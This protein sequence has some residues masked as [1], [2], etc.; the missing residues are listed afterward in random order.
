MPSPSPLLPAAWLARAHPASS[1]PNTPLG[2]AAITR[3]N[4]FLDLTTSQWETFLS[5]CQSASPHQHEVLGGCPI[6]ITCP[7]AFSV[8]WKQLGKL[9]EEKEFHWRLKHKDLTFGLGSLW[10]VIAGWPSI[11]DKCCYTLPL[12]LCSSLGINC[13]HPGQKIG[14]EVTW[15]LAQ[16][17]W[18]LL[19][20]GLDLCF[21]KYIRT[22]LQGPRKRWAEAFPSTFSLL[23]I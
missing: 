22:S 4:S 9:R 20:M 11:V 19:Y 8:G 15:S 7:A 3:K 18:L 23:L 12:F 21:F 13:Y 16:L 5:V 2:F 10:A 6:S 14:H 17:L 1:S